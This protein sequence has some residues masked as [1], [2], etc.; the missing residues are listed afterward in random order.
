MDFITNLLLWYKKNGRQLPMRQTRDPY[1]TWISEII[2][3]Q[4]RIEQGMP[5]YD[6]FLH[7]FPNIIA[8]AD[9]N[10]DEVLSAWQGL[11]YY[12]RARYLHCTAKF[13]VNQLN[14][15][16]PECYDDIIQLKG[17]GSYTA[18]AI[19][20]WCFGEQKMAID[21]NVYRV[22]SRFFDIDRNIN[23]AAGR[24][25]FDKLGDQLIQ[26]GDA[27]EIN[28]ALIDLGATVCLPA[29]PN[30]NICPVHHSCLAVHRNTIQYRPVKNLPQKVKL[31]YFTYFAINYKNK[32]LLRKRAENDIWKGLYE[33]PLIETD[34]FAEAGQLI[35][36]D[37]L[38][39]FIKKA[40]NRQI[41]I[42]EMPKHVLSH[43]VIFSRFV[44]VK[45]DAEPFTNGYILAEIGIDDSF[46]MPVLLENFMKNRLKGYI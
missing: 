13:I 22:L 37:F 45:V 28:Q 12:S 27:G 1:K 46:P 44:V 7:K 40:T 29:N 36:A 32:F 30:C 11:G 20:S 9:A 19:A 14:G 15:H 38:D 8:L 3:Q 26:K 24:K 18:A 39:Q 42:V 33:F 41:E 2:F 17:I 23:T 25:Q 34:Q 10:E 4:T 35:I 21:G 6:R 31:R 16:F 5:Y 43:Q